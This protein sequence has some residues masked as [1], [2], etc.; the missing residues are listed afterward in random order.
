MFL[1]SLFISF[2][3]TRMQPKQMSQVN[4][5]NMLCPAVSDPFHGK[6]YRLIAIG[7]QL[8]LI[9][10][11]GKVFL[12]LAKA[13]NILPCGQPPCEA[14]IS[15]I[16]H[17]M[18][19]PCPSVSQT[20]CVSTKT[21]TGTNCSSSS[22]DSGLNNSDDL[23]CCGL[24]LNSTP[25]NVCDS[26]PPI[27]CCCNHQESA[28]SCNGSIRDGKA[29]ENVDDCTT[30]D[31]IK[32]T[33]PCV[34]ANGK[35]KNGGLDLDLD[36]G[37]CNRCDQMNRV[38]VSTCANDDNTMQ[39][40]KVDEATTCLLDDGGTSAS[41]SSRPFYVT[42]RLVNGTVQPDEC[43]SQQSQSQNQRSSAASCPTK[44]HHHQPHHHSSRRRSG[45]GG[46][47]LR[48]RGDCDPDCPLT[49]DDLNGHASA[50]S[51]GHAKSH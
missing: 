34:S 22:T 42:R 26:S 25:N 45:S 3:S 24:N 11:L 40:Q 10:T 8:I 14:P 7:H 33:F 35:K 28:I 5:N 39:T 29:D 15:Q 17:E 50:S 4:L 43:Q 32:D 27:A 36:G 44:C 6:Y 1:I 37:E 38:E 46:G 16:F 47:S 23:D 20:C 2:Y 30:G 18:V 13:F 21:T 12:L 51:N 49:L 9:P 19:A 41:S 48:A 31:K